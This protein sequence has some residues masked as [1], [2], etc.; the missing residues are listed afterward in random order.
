MPKYL[1]ILFSLILLILL[2]QVGTSLGM[3]SAVCLL[4]VLMSCFCSSHGREKKIEKRIEKI[5]E[6]QVDC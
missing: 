3:L 2:I 5:H 4:S 1:K 6:R